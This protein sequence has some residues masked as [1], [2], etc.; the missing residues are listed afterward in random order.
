MTLIFF[1]FWFDNKNQ[2]I[3]RL[4]N[5]YPSQC[6][7]VL[8][9]KWNNVIWELALKL[10]KSFS[11]ISSWKKLEPTLRNT[12]MMSK[13]EIVPIQLLAKRWITLYKSKGQS[14]RPGKN[15]FWQQLLIKVHYGKTSP[16]INHHNSIYFIHYD[17]GLPLGTHNFLKSQ[18]FKMHNLVWQS[19]SLWSD[20]VL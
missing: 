6:E 2:S 19:E 3:F 18:W 16:H 8:T 7:N 12:V 15:I 11:K 4:K 9:F 1:S 10:R 14:M 5:A 20:A 13:L 17:C